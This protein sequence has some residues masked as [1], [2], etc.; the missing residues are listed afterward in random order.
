MKK[1]YGKGWWLILYAFLA[2]FTATAVGSAMN[3]ASG[4]LA[5]LYSWNAAV[6]TSLIS[7]GSIANI[8]AA[9]VLGNLSVQHSAKHLSLICF[10]IYT[11]AMI[12]LGLSGNFLVFAVCLIL[13]NGISSGIGYQLSP[14]L[15][16][17]WF[18]K[19]KGVVMGIV[20]MG[21]P[22][23][24]GV[25]T[26]IYQVGFKRIGGNFGGFLPF[27]AIYC[28]WYSGG[29]CSGDHAFRPTEGSRIYSR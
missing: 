29:H 26:M 28:H 4:T 18:P 14:V 5:G 17:R 9:V 13:A 1:G 24:S 16:S 6:L 11:L 2:Y 15:I 25:A 27:I 22:L 10:A 12:G 3:V 23:C 7:L 19:R 21:I 8:L 20:T